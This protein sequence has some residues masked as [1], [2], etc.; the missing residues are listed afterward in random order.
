MVR[1]GGKLYHNQRTLKINA[2]FWRLNNGKRRQVKNPNS[3]I[4]SELEGDI[5]LELKQIFMAKH[6]A[7]TCIAKE[8]LVKNE[9]KP[10]SAFDE[11]PEE[12]KN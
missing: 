11:F 1:Y 3:L 8:V 10:V 6:K 2:P 12:K 7:I 9:R 4:G 5:H